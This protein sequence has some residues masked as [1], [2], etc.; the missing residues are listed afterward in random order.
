MKSS[1]DAIQEF[2]SYSSGPEWTVP[3][4]FDQE[5]Y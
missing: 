3:E 1:Q 5:N 2:L 4:G